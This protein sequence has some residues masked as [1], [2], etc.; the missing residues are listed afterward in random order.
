MLPSASQTIAYTGNI[1]DGDSTTIYGNVYGDVH[2]AGRSGEPTRQQCL[3]D[4]RVTDPREDKARIDQEKDKLLKDCYAWILDDS[5]FQRWRTQDDP[6]LLWIKGDPGK[7]KT[8][9]MI[10]VISELSRRNNAKPPQNIMS[11]VRPN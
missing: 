1:A 10:G 7:G 9:L 6:R 2:F 8:M 11:K 3:C 4:L 5:S